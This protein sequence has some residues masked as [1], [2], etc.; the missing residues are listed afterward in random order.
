MG[1]RKTLYIVLIVGLVIFLVSL[2]IGRP[3]WQA[4][5]FGIGFLLVAA[6]VSSSGLVLPKSLFGKRFPGRRSSGKTAEDT[7]KDIFLMGMNSV[8]DEF[9]TDSGVASEG[10]QWVMEYKRVMQEI[11]ELAYEVHENVRSKDRVKLRQAFREAVKQLPNLI[12]EFERIPDP[13]DP[14]KQEIMNRQAEGLDLYLV[15]CSNFTKAADTED[16]DLA[17]QAAKQINEALNLLN[18]MDKPTGTRGWKR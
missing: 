7:E 17:G 2:I 18:L 9:S 12:S 6:V 5:L 10:A 14:R 1:S 4:A 13:I 8:L 3:P 16:G 15:A 11:G